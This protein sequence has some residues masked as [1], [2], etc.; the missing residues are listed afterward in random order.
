MTN[1]DDIA[2]EIGNYMRTYGRIYCHSKEK[3]DTVRIYTS[4]WTGSLHGLTHPGYVYSR[5]PDWLWKLD[6]LY[7]TRL[8]TFLKLDVIINKYQ[9]FIY[10]RAYARAVNK[11]PKLERN[12]L[13]CADY[14]E[15][16][17]GLGQTKG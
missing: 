15:L 13:Q 11:Y 5:Y 8:T 10:R 16:L 6:C 4:F 17:N 9:R 12:I 1:L 3:Y 14:P 7:I 2:Y